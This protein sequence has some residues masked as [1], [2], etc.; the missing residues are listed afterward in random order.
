[1][2]FQVF[3]ARAAQVPAPVNPMGASIPPVRQTSGTDS[4]LNLPSS[5][6]IKIISNGPALGQMASP[7]AVDQAQPPTIPGS[8]Q[9]IP[10]PM[11]PPPAAPP[12]VS[13]APAPTPST[14]P[15]ACLKAIQL[16][17]GTV[18]N[19]DDVIT[20]KDLCAMIP[21]LKEAGLGA[22]K[23]PVRPGGPIPVVSNTPG[24]M[25][26]GLPSFGP[27]GSPFGQGGGGGGGGNVVV[28]PGPIGVV[29][30]PTPVGGPGQGT[31][32]PIG[33]VGPA[34]AG[35]IIDGVQKNNANFFNSGAMAIVPGTTFTITVGGNG[36]VS[37][38]FSFEMSPN[39][40]FASV[41]N[42]LA[43]IQIDSTQYELWRKDEIQ[44]AGGD[45]V[46]AMSAAGV[47]FIN[48]SP[49]THTISLIYGSSPA[50]NPWTLVASPTNPAS[51]IAQHS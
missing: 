2:R 41:Y 1:M 12:Q 29:T 7:P 46:T 39:L 5:A 17:D 19:P 33:P 22:P 45:R 3:A 26:G 27:A 4:R 37:L 14:L 18:I 34:G 31:Q 16:P 8:R 21:Y 6:S 25:M 40:G 15:A 28:G 42:V 23:G 35:S 38:F 48:L 13:A 9:D 36:N 24:Q 47:L 50:G 30:G 44:G 32:G 10:I 51:I 43:G 49:G 11:T 20:L